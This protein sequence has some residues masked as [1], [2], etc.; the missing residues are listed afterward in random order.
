MAFWTHFCSGEG[1]R[2]GTRTD[3]SDEATG[4][5]NPSVVLFLDEEHGSLCMASSKGSR[6]VERATVSLNDFLVSP[7]REPR[8]HILRY[9]PAEEKTRTF[10]L[11]KVRFHFHGLECCGLTVEQ[12]YSSSVTKRL[13]LTTSSAPTFK[14]LRLGPSDG[15]E[16]PRK[17]PDHHAIAE[18]CR[19][20]GRACD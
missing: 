11:G 8:V 5:D 1:L 12:R 18:S 4:I 6:R 14:Q 20:I 17:Y 13:I 2:F 16:C 19:Q 15:L 9:W 3:T 10:D 7:E